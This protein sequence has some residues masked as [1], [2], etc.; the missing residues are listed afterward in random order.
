MKDWFNTLILNGILH[1][2]KFWYAISSVIVPI[3]I[4]KL[5]VDE[6]TA[7]NLFWALIALTGAQGI[8]DIGKKK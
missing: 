5:G 8:A 2:K 1:S 3:I 7:T 6:L 4:S